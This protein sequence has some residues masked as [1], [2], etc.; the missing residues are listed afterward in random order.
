MDKKTWHKIEDIADRALSLP[1]TGREL[2]ISKE[3]HGDTD[4]QNE[5]ET[6][7]KSI[8]DS[9]GWLEDP[10]DFIN[11]LFKDL[12][13]D[14]DVLQSTRSLIGKKVGAY[15][16][17]KE[18]ARGGMGTVFL[19]ERTDGV[20]D[21]KVAIKL[22]NADRATA[23]NIERFK[24]ERNILAE[25]NQPGI[26]HIYD[27]GLTADGVPYFIM[28]YIDGIPITEYCIQNK[29]PLSD[30][31]HLFKKVLKAVQ[32]AHEN[33]IVHQD[34]KPDN[35]LVTKEEDIKIL[36]FGISKLLREETSESV[37]EIKKQALTLSYA[38]PE[39]IKQQSITTAT[40]V[41][42]L[43][44]VFYK[45]LTNRLP[46]SL[47]VLLF[48]E[49]YE[50]ILSFNPV[51][52]SSNVA[53][54]AGL[55]TKDIRSDLDAIILKALQ[56]NQRSRYR[57]AAA[58]LVDLN[59]FEQH[60]PVSACKH[61]PTYISKKYLR[62]NAK[63]LSIAAFF[64]ML[65]ISFASF[66]TLRITEQK[67]QAQ[68]AALKAEEISDFL[69]QLFEASDPASNLGN[70]FTT[71]ELLKNGVQ[72]SE[73]LSSQPLLQARLFDITGQ[74]YR[75]IGNFNQAKYLIENAISLRE[76]NLGYYHPLTLASKHNLGLVLNDI[77]DYHEAENIFKLVYDQRK[78]IL[79]NDHVET[80][81]TLSNLAYS[82]R[83]QGDYTLAEELARESLNTF[84]AKLGTHNIQ[85]LDIMNKLAIT[86]H[87]KGEYQEAEK[88]YLEVL[89]KRKELLG[90]PHPEVAKSINNLATLYL[91]TGQFLEA[92]SLMNEALEIQKEL[93]GPVHP[94]VA[95]VINNLGLVNTELQDYERAGTYFE[96]ALDMRLEIL[97]RDH[98]NTAIS[99]FS[100]GNLML[101]IGRPD[102]AISN[103]EEAISIFKKELS[104]DHSFMAHSSLGIGR[105][106]SQKGLLEKAEP[107]YSDSFKRIK[108]IHQ[109]Y[110]IERAMAEYHVGRFYLKKGQPSYANSLLKSSYQ[111]LKRI[112]GGK[113]NRQLKVLA[114]L[115]QT[116]DL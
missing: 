100:I 77:G 96:E 14:L 103:F 6:L 33:L 95:V 51:P 63:S 64:L 53:S 86:L 29:L 13:D 78:R 104:D 3:C 98:T 49:A 48:T 11:D 39:Q 45:S 32:H 85:T 59:S 83:R 15:T 105:A 87:N 43:G 109:N 76:R 79:G 8:T 88:I 17:I 102:S 1:A 27:G 70:V 38:A 18:I 28:E 60:L 116:E 113:Q 19:A 107:Y 56:K 61:D 108:E 90:S 91:N 26:A 9:E 115:Q 41:Y 57:S 69:I 71:R 81:S 99:F 30:R 97:G 47:D 54:N 25:L 101:E 93:F 35:I 36:D 55:T 22:I 40:D 68:A 5:V 67:K 21:H 89:E 112:E 4:L 23:E 20:F 66:Y 110:S 84:T 7:I 24:Q 73:Q 94:N 106:L 58:L 75:N 62:R 52:P 92:K 72:K 80:A 31:I 37:P 74:V 82:I 10:G 34:L 50:K 2:F 16:I 46:Y 44:L 65:I 42:S 114:T 12:P 111:A